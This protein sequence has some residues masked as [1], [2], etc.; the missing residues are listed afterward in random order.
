VASIIER[1][2]LACA[3]NQVGVPICWTA[4]FILFDNKNFAWFTVRKVN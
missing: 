1:I 2:D 3:S 4:L